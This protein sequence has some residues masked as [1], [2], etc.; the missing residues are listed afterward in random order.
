MLNFC[1]V[2]KYLFLLSSAAQTLT[3]PI[4]LEYEY[5]P[6]ILINMHYN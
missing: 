2:V 1:K 3:I 6:F 4:V 5:Y